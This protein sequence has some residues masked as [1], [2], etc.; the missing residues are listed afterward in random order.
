MTASPDDLVQE[1]LILRSWGWSVFPVQ[2]K[3]P[4]VRWRP[5]QHRRPSER[6]IERMFRLEGVDGIAAVTGPVSG[7]L[8]N[9]DYDDPNAYHRWADGHR[10]LA[11]VA[12]TVRTRRGFRVCARSDRPV[13]RKCGDGEVIGDSKHYVVMPPS[14]HPK[15]GDYTWLAGAPL[16]PS[17]FPRLDPFK[18]GFLTNQCESEL[19][20]GP[21]I[22]HY[23]SSVSS[24][25]SGEEWSEEDL[26]ESIRECALRTQPTVVGQRNG[27]LFQ[28]ARSLRDLVPRD[29][30][31][32]RL[33]NAVRFWWLKAVPV[34]GT[35]EFATTANDFRRAWS[36]VLVPISCS[37]PILALKRGAALPAQDSRTRLLNVCRELAREKIDGTFYLSARTAA[38]HIGLKKTQAADLLKALVSGGEVVVVR[39]GRSSRSSRRGTTVYRM[40]TARHTAPP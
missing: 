36:T 20:R 16:G 1:A 30:P 8:V 14:R 27:R 19:P 25:C 37:K 29:A 17:E 2:R 35:K 12:P 26:P 4:A 11:R 28:F 7:C 9:R 5:Y 40:G 18:A 38:E 13:Y 39:R 10:E 31:P 3:R 21:D 6:E 23:A 24:L 32:R 33:A 34:I 15:G 22:S